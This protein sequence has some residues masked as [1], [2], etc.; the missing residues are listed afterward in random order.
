MSVSVDSAESRLD[1]EECGA[2][3]TV[4]LCGVGPSFDLA[5][6]VAGHAIEGLDA[7]GGT[8]ASFQKR[9]HSEVMEG[10]RFRQSFPQTRKCRLVHQS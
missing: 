8:E 2:E 9:E 4:S 3:P 7:V 6:E 10:Q 1:V 5:R